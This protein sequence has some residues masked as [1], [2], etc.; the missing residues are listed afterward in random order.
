MERAGLSFSVT[1]MRLEEIVRDNDETQYPF[2]PYLCAQ[3]SEPSRFP[4]TTPR[5]CQIVPI[6]IDLP[7]ARLPFFS[8]NPLPGSECVHAVA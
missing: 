5:G 2:A 1:F 7:G 4:L 8:E 6:P 3:F